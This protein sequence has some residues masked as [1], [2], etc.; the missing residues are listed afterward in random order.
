LGVEN[1]SRTGA[2]AG[3]PTSPERLSTR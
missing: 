1:D 3:R 2:T